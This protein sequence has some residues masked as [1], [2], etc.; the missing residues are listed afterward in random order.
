MSFR[1]ASFYD[2]LLRHAGVAYCVLDEQWKVVKV[3]GATCRFFAMSE[4]ELLS[5]SAQE[6]I[7]DF[8]PEAFSS[9]WRALEDGASFMLSIAFRKH[10]QSTVLARIRPDALIMPEGR[11]LILLLEDPGRSFV[12]GTLLREEDH[13]LRRLVDELP[14]L[15]YIKDPS[16]RLIF[17][18]KANLEE[19]GCA[20]K[21]G[22]LLGKTDREIFPGD[23]SNL[24]ED[25]DR[26]VLKGRPVINHL[27]TVEG[28]EGTSKHLRITKVPIYSEDGQFMA[29]A[30][31]TKDVTVEQNSIRAVEAAEQ[32]FRALVEN[33]LA[34][35]FV[36][37]NGRISYC[38][39]IFAQFFGYSQQEML[40]KES[41]L[42]LIAPAQR[43]KIAR[44][45]EQQIRL[46]QGEIQ[47]A[48]EG[49]TRDG[50][51]VHIEFICARITLDGSPTLIGTA[52]DITDRKE[53]E[54]RIRLAH[55]METVGTLAGE[56]AHD[57]N[58]LLTVILGVTSLL[59]LNRSLEPAIHAQVQQVHQAAEVAT[60]IT[61]QL[62]TLSQRR[63]ADF[64]TRDMNQL[65]EKWRAMLRHSLRE[66][67]QMEILPCDEPLPI[68][69]D[70]SMF[71]QVIL[72]I[73][74]NARDAMPRGGKFRVT[75]RSAK[76]D[77]EILLRRSGD[78]KPGR[79]AILTISDT[80]C[81]MPPEI[82][83]RLFEPY[84]TTKQEDVTG[85]TGT[86]L[87]M[88][89]VYNIVRQHSGWID[90]ESEV[91]RGTTFHLY[92]PIHNVNDAPAA[93]DTGPLLLQP[94]K[95][96]LILLIED[97]ARVR[98][99]AI[100][101]LER[102]G[103]TVVETEH[104][105]QALEVWEKRKDEIALIFSDIVLPGKINGV[106]FGRRVL[107]EKPEVRLL[108]TSGFNP[109]SSG[110]QLPS[111]SAFLAKPYS[112]EQLA[113]ILRRLFKQ[114]PSL[115]TEKEPA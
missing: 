67:I 3:N 30:G 13:L 11:F 111:G 70:E 10:D 16:L 112:I 35:I 9:M 15:M 8:K 93:K 53:S 110:T 31:I 107:A 57:F 76:I 20:D 33:S 74:V 26:E 72:N 42:D 18:N 56:I 14:D 64:R 98:T 1:D 80:G 89:I 68:Q 55:K 99:L 34:G 62:L 29:I 84:F 23:Q 79:Y 43:E 21:P 40:A 86:G 103:Y 5:C 38:N 69:A 108:L 87:G 104:A 49:R 7:T 2:A 65:L 95:G 32:R 36:I 88:S 75:T 37:Q 66:D 106:E 58:N 81:G 4:Q 82:L 51:P 44:Q 52:L 12:S 109:E 114:R 77:E 61:R 24:M 91:G 60:Q 102:L 90:V 78:S 92:F 94:G 25:E 48:F 27:R 115:L 105:D 59:K 6:L 28:S 85:T 100:M 97:D 17:L 101:C 54:D 113:Q 96:E 46:G 47:R 63:A 71:E 19:L 45:M 83:T 73:T 22:A 39:P 41:Y 50:K